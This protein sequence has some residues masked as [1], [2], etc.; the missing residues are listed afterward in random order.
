MCLTSYLLILVILFKI[1]LVLTHTI[2][3]SSVATHWL[4]KK[5][6]AWTTACSKI[7]Q[8]LPFQPLILPSSHRPFKL[9]A[10]PATSLLLRLHVSLGFALANVTSCGWTLFP[11]LPIGNSYPRDSKFPYP[12]MV[13]HMVYKSCLKVCFFHLAVSS[14]RE[15]Y[16]T[17]VYLHSRHSVTFGCM[18][19][20]GR[21]IA[22]W[23]G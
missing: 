10:H 15:L 16:H 23:K 3:K 12:N 2:F 1:N 14:L 22:I 8:I 9:Q 7:W 5:L 6:L 19:K 4:K 13:H 20:Q 21:S 17:W 11:L 18:K